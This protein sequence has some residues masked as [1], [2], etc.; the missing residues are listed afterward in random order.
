MMWHLNH[1]TT[2]NYKTD[3][4]AIV[5]WKIESW[6]N[7][8]SSCTGKKKIMLLQKLFQSIVHTSA[9]LGTWFQ[10]S[11]LL[12][13]PAVFL[14][15]S[16]RFYETVKGCHSRLM[17]IRWSVKTKNCQNDWVSL[18][19]QFENNTTRW[20]TAWKNKLAMIFKNNWVWYKYC[21]ILELQSSPYWL[22]KN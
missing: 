17:F 7:W 2:L 14:S 10:S 21:P 16:S 12:L 8:S 6:R 15:P 3:A 9:F 19:L 11:L 4:L 1:W 22:I 5:L 13:S 18:I 20:F